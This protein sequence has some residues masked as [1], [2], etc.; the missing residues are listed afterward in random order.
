MKGSSFTSDY[1]GV[2]SE[3]SGDR[4]P[5]LSNSTLRLKGGLNDHRTTDRLQKDG[6]IHYTRKAVVEQVGEADTLPAT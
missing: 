5:G 2:A 4:V 3:K 6:C 1:H